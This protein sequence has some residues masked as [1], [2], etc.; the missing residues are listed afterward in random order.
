MVFWPLTQPQIDSSPPTITRGSPQMKMGEYFVQIPP[1]P[2][3]FLASWWKFPQTL[4]QSAVDC[5]S[6]WPAV[7]LFQQRNRYGRP[8]ATYIVARMIRT[9]GCWPWRHRKRRCGGSRRAPERRFFEYRKWLSS[10]WRSR[11]WCFQR[12]CCSGWTLPMYPL[13]G[14]MVGGAVVGGRVVINA[15]NGSGEVV[16]S[17]GWGKNHL[18][19]LCTSPARSF[20]NWR[21]RL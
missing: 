4:T 5:Y 2:T 20:W 21:T 14:M 9:G 17:W 11:F 10:A 15:Q 8:P 13:G 6:F 1:R 18:K 7:G 16:V 12:P 19:S 3:A